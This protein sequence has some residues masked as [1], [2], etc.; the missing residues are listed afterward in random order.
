MYLFA[1][2]IT[3]SQPVKIDCDRDH[4]ALT[5]GKVL[6]TYGFRA[7]LSVLNSLKHLGIALTAV[8]ALG[9]G[10]WTAMR[11]RSP[12]A[13]LME[14]QSGVLLSQ[15][16]P[17]AE[18]ALTDQDNKPFTQAQLRGRWSLVFAG[19]THC[20]D[21]C[22]T[23]LQLMKQLEARL[24]LENRVISPLFLSLDP[25]RDTPEQLQR[26]VRYFSPHITG[27]TGAK[28]QL[29]QLCASLGIAYVIVPGANS[30]EYTIDHSSALVLINPQGQIAGYFQAPHK[31]DTLATDL[32]RVIAEST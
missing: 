21:V 2:G 20:P 17:V 4:P 8:A 15:P 6:P 19:F 23:T 18:F 12:S 32:A 11:L 30:T 10:I 24:R 1:G 13:S 16:R 22:P 26:Y 31:L 27:V 14:L 5:V 25:Q 7:G 9:L 29:D 28:E 3:K